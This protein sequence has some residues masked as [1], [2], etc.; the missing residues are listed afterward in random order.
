M[1]LGVAP[2]IA[3]LNIIFPPLQTVEWGAFLSRALAEATL[4][5]LI[6]IHLSVFLFRQLFF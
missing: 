1:D 5:I 6:F 2:E 3:D 4:G